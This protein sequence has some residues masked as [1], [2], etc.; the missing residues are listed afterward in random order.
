[1]DIRAVN[2]YTHAE[3]HAVWVVFASTSRI[4]DFVCNDVLTSLLI[5]CRPRFLLESLWMVNGFSHLTLNWDG[6]RVYCGLG[7]LAWRLFQGWFPSW[8]MV[9]SFNM[10]SLSSCFRV[11]Y[12]LVF[13]G[14]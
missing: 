4:A 11:A 12:S 5:I 2:D 9:H 3:N 8:A 13:D 10:L 6:T 7:K 1:M 14:G